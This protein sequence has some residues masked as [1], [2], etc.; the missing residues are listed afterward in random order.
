MNLTLMRTLLLMMGL[1]GLLRSGVLPAASCPAALA[2]G[3]ATRP[4]LPANPNCLYGSSNCLQAGQGIADG[5]E[6]EGVHG[7]GSCGWVAPRHDLGG[8]P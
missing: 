3:P 7:G 5:G 6:F 2:F 8:E 1:A 4:A